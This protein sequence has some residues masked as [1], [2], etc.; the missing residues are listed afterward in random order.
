MSSIVV[1]KQSET[2][3]A[4][5]GSASATVAILQGVLKQLFVESATTT[6]T[7][8]VNLVDIHS[9]TVYE[10]NDITGVLNEHIDL[11]AYGNYT[12]NIANASVDENFTYLATF[13]EQT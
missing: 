1:H 11:P 8:D 4:S 5:G 12:L 3:T 9:L 13:L 7:F 10:F 2:I 6:T